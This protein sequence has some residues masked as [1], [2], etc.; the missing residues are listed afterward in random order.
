MAN[1]G[2]SMAS[3]DKQ[4]EGGVEHIQTRECASRKMLFV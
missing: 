4:E 2:V 3:E 1:L